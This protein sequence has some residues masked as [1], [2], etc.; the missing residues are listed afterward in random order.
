MAGTIIRG[1]V[2]IAPKNTVFL[3]CDLQT[4][5]SLSSDAHAR[6]EFHENT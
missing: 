6:S 5:L 2:K 3:V 1:V 4:R